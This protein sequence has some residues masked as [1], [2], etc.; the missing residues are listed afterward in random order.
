MFVIKE[1]NKGTSFLYVSMITKILNYFN[2]CMTNLTYRSTG[3]TQEFSQ[4]TLTNMSYFWDINHQA[5]Y[6][7]MGKNGKKIYNFDDSAQFGDD[8]TEGHMDDEQLIGT[9]NHVPEGDAVI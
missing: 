1:C 7:R 2:I 3:L 6:F 9:S 5:Y 4:C 8:A